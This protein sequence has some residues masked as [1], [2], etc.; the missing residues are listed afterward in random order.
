MDQKKIKNILSSLI[1]DISLNTLNK[2]SNI[3]IKS[4]NNLYKSLQFSPKTKSLINKMNKDLYKEDEED[5]NN[6]KKE[7]EKEENNEEKDEKNK[8]K[9]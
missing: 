5:I 4:K 1:L 7:K 6:K 2:N 8:E 3:N 9:E